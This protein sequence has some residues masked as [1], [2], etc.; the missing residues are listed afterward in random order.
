MK[1]TPDGATTETVHGWADLRFVIILR[2]LSG[3]CPGA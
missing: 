3:V 1:T 2:T